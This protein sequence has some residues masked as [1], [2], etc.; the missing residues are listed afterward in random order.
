MAAPTKKP[1]VAMP[2]SAANDT[3]AIA[4][5]H[6]N[7]AIIAVAAMASTNSPTATT[8]P[9]S[10]VQNLVRAMLQNQVQFVNSSGSYTSSTLGL[11]VYPLYNL[12][13]QLSSVTE[14]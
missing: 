6:V 3:H 4:P 7:V 5:K 13:T 11:M 1:T 8:F 12:F 9:A 2:I 10:L 14:N